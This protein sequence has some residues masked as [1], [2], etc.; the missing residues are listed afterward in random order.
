MDQNRNNPNHPQDGNPPEKNKP[1]NIWTALIITLALVL[2][3]SWIFNAVSNSQYTETTYSDFLDAMESGNLQEVEIRYDRIVYLTK[4]EAA[5]PA[6]SQKACFTGLRGGGDTMALAQKLHDMGVTVNEPIVEDNSTIMMVLYYGISIAVLFLFMRMLTKRMSGDGM[7]G[8]FGKSKAKMYMEKQTGVT[9]KDVAGQDEA[10]ESLEEII[11]FLHNPKKYT[12]IGAKLP[13]GALL[14][15]SPGTGKTLLAKAVAGEANVP[16]FS[17]SG[18]DFV[19]MFVGMGASRVRDLFQQAAKV[20][21]CIIFIDEIDAVGRARDNRFGNNSEQEQT[22]NQL[23]SEIDGFE[24]SKGIVCLAATNRPEILD[25]ALLRPGRFDRQIIV[26]KPNLQGRLDTLKVHTRKIKLSEDVDLRKIAQA[27]AGAV[28]ADLA[29][30][31]NEAALRAVRKGRKAVNQEDLMASFETVIAG[32]EKKNTVLTDMEKRLVAYHEVGHAL[33]A[34]LEKHAQPVSK[35]TIVP[36]TSGALGYTMQMPEEEKFLNTAEELMTE[37]RTLVGGRAAEQLVFGVQTTGAANDL[38]RATALA[39]NMVTQ[40][41]MSKELGLMTTAS[42][43]NAYL[44]GQAYMD[45]AQTTA[46]QVDREVK[47]LLDSALADALRILREHR[48]LLDEVSEYLLVKETITGDELMAYVNAEAASQIEASQEVPSPTQEP[49]APSGP[50]PAPNLPVS[51]QK[52][53]NSER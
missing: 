42:V 6:Q 18:S 35:I 43:Q 30:L 47:S 29:N 48:G 32:T 24:P 9:F 44:D 12:E 2:I 22:L 53:G 28:G 37:L 46:A 41:G 50:D 10:K 4:D 33:V 23:L 31:V 39:R 5:K 36:H 52:E 16:F 27:T 45:C 25:K 11:D 3:F 15:G 51:E 1:R 7:M 38:Q 26:D 40:Y 19:E 14:V 8:G 21:P 20:A 49:A 17:I 13:K 34:A